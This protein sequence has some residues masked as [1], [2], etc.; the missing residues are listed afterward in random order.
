MLAILMLNLFAGC[1]VVGWIAAIV[2]AFIIP[3]EKP[4][5]GTTAPAPR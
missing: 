2:W 3:T 1:T 4:Q 5:R